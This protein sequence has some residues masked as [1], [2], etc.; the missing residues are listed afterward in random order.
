MVWVWM[1][2]CLAELFIGLPPVP[3]R[4]TADWY[5]EVAHY[6]LILVIPSSLHPTI[7]CAVEL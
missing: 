2:N 7:S 5:Y 4:Q 1:V 6:S 3:L